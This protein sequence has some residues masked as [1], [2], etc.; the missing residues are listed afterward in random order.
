L[1]FS[2]FE[3]TM[4]TLFAYKAVSSVITSLAVAATLI[5]MFWCMMTFQK[6]IILCFWQSAQ[7]TEINTL[8]LNQNHIDVWQLMSSHLSWCDTVLYK[9]MLS[10]SRVRMII[11]W[12]K[13]VYKASCCWSTRTESASVSARMR[14][15]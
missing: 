3:M 13:W 15:M 12:E 4:S 8:T 14:T 2:S 10:L 11:V 9:Q 7:L 6:S 5:E 1:L